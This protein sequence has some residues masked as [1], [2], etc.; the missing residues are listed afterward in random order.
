MPTIANLAAYYLDC[1]GRDRDD[2]ISVFISNRY[3]NPDYCQLFQSPAQIDNTVCATQDNAVRGIVSRARRSSQSLE[4][5]V[6]YPLLVNWAT[7]Q[8]GNRFGT[9]GPLFF[10]ACE[11]G[12]ADQSMPTLGQEPPRLNPDAIARLAGFDKKEVI[13][14]MLNLYSELGFDRPLA[15]QPDLWQAAEQLAQLRTDWNWREEINPN[16]FSTGILAA[17]TEANTP[18]GVYNKAAFFIVERSKFTQGLEQELGQIKTATATQTA[19]SILQRMVSDE[20]VDESSASVQLIEPLPLN[21]EQREAVR[22]ALT[23]PLTAV[24]GPPGTGKSQVVASIIINAIFHGQTVLFSSKN[25]KAVDVVLERV[26]NLT[27]RSVMI[28]LGRD[29][30]GQDLRGQLVTYLNDILSSAANPEESSRYQFFLKRHEEINAEW[31]KLRAKEQDVILRRNRL[32]QLERECEQRREEFGEKQ[33]SA[34]GQWSAEKIAHF[35]A[36]AVTLSCLFQKC[37][38]SQQ[39]LL[40]RTFWPFLSNSRWSGFFNAQTDATVILEEAQ[41]ETH[42]NHELDDAH[43]V[44]VKKWLDLLEKR[45][46]AIQQI[47]EYFECVNHISDSISLF[48]LARQANICEDSLQKNSSCLWETWLQLL[49]S[50]LTQQER[51]CLSEFS[52][53]LQQISALA[54]NQQGPATK[55]IWANYYAL[56]PQVSNILPCWAVTSLSLKG[57]V[58]FEAG[59]F[60]LVV[61]DEAS[62]CDIASALPLLF[63]AKRAVIIGDVKQLRHICSLNVHENAMLQERYGLNEGGLNWDYQSKSLFEMAQSLLN[64]SNLINLRDHHRSHADIIGFSNKHFYDG[65]LR[66]ATRYEKLKAL[67]G[68]TAVRWIDQP[69]KVQPLR[70]GGSLN[71][72]EAVAICREIRRIVNMGYQGTLGVVSPFRAQ[73]NRIRDMIAADSQLEDR[74][75]L[76]EFM[77]ETV[78]RFQGDERD[79]MIFSPV[80]AEG[81]GRGS[82]Q[83]LNSTGNLFNVSLTRARAALIIVGDYS[84]CANNALSPDYLRKFV[85]YQQRLSQ[86]QDGGTGGAEKLGPEYPAI[87]SAQ[88]VSDWEKILYKAL[89]QAGIRTRPQYQVMQYSLDMALID[90]DRKLDIEVD[91]EHYH[92]A[93][94]GELCR[95]DQLRNRRL[96]ELGWDVLRFWVYEVRDNLPACVERI[97]AWQSV[98]Q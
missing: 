79:V 60:D 76:R 24:T 8:K 88:L 73:V 78:H 17:A 4:L 64:P 61:I 6:G 12:S 85:I 9:I 68:G 55:K 39:G 62:Q 47:R 70:T 57:R 7:S 1:I 33:F 26:N 52:T 66:V 72:P 63:R 29:S 31:H 49:P 45:I 89:Y 38:R 27:N 95:R 65:S 71:E 2:G 59:F 28:R 5:V 50:R 77:V 74:L 91:G 13:P 34:F 48:E 42:C 75:R 16:V 43:L 32:D 92:R 3:G 94:D 86:V 22:K 21:D 98:P 11:I 67:A 58:P 15:E 44:E 84:F 25:N 30:S 97:R 87:S 20:L 69:G 14:E 54:G 56:L 35:R 90:G 18:A 10:Q 23:A 93:W 19:G 37:D 46:E 40:T 83:F 96:I 82:V 41:L 51:R 81:I 53:I 36:V 80:I